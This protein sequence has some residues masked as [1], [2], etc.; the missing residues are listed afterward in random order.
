VD[1]KDKAQLGSVYDDKEEMIEEWFN[2]NKDSEMIKYFNRYLN[3]KEDD[4]EMQLIKEEMKL[5][6]FNNKNLIKD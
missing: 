1:A 3:L 5:M 2:E 4:K 6:M